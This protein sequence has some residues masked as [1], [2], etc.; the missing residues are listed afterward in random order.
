MAR[1]TA[2]DYRKELEYLEDNLRGV[3][4]SISIRLLDL[5]ALNPEAPIAK[6]AN[7]E[8][9]IIKAKSLNNKYIIEDMSVD[10][11]LKYI[12]IIEKYLED[13]HPHKQTKINF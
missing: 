6:E 11:Q 4:R 3:K 8:G 9:T 1:K 2:K 7:L 12:E 13:L 10:T 5:C